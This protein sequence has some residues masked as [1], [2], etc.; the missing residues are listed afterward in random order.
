M[1]GQ[2]IDIDM[3]FTDTSNKDIFEYVKDNLDFDTLIWEFMNE[4]GTPRWVHVSYREGKNRNQI[5]EAYKD[6]ATGLTKYKIYEPRKEKKETKG[7]KSRPVSTRKDRDSKQ[8][9]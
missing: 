5:L 9:T 8:S 6:E 2:A 7:N 4:D 3:D 1:T